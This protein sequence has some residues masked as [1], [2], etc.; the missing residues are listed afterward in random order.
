MRTNDRHRLSF[1]GT[2]THQPT[3]HATGT[4]LGYE[5]PHIRSVTVETVG[6]AVEAR[7]RAPR[8]LSC[9]DHASVAFRLSPM[10]SV[11]AEPQGV[12]AAAA[13]A[14][15]RAPVLFVQGARISPPAR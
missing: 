9:T 6:W 2:C 4:S 14:A 15:A 12:G 10:F 3:R 8:S 11:A 1:D 7:V 13:T 5:G